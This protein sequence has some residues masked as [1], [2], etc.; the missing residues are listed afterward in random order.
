MELG[1]LDRAEGRIDFLFFGEDLGTQH[2]PLISPEL[3]R[4]VLKPFH[5]R[6]TDVLLKKHPYDRNSNF[7]S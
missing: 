7:L 5:K 1:I 2:T 4:R 6:Y 3:Y